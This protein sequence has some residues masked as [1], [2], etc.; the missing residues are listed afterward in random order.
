MKKHELELF[1]TDMNSLAPLPSQPRSHRKTKSGVVTPRII[2]R[3][4][5]NSNSQSLAPA[6]PGQVAVSPS[7]RNSKSGRKRI[8]PTVT[9]GSKGPVTPGS[10][11]PVTPRDRTRII[12]TGTPGSEGLVTSC[13]RKQIITTVTPGSN[14]RK[15]SRNS[16]NENRTNIS[17]QDIRDGM[18]ALKKG[19]GN[20]KVVTEKGELGDMLDKILRCYKHGYCADRPGNNVEGKHV[21][22]L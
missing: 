14:M 8:I 18:E 12:A 19:F 1:M 15:D 21:I 7:N 3:S 6:P 4:S 10:K 2:Y 22:K 5:N 13:G 9:P 16:R 17:E 11:G 20:F